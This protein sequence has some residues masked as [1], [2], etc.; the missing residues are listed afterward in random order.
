MGPASVSFPGNKLLAEYDRGQH[1]E[2]QKVP[3]RLE[4]QKQVRAQNDRKWAK[5]QYPFVAARPTHQHVQ[6]VGENDLTDNQ[7]NLVIYLAPVPSPVGINGH[8]HH[9]LHIVNWSGEELVIQPAS[10]SSHLL[11]Q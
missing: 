6:D 8:V 4:P 7:W 5:S 2:L 10:R 11:A 1:Q 3:V 9:E